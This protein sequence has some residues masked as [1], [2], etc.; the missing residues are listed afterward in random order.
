MKAQPVQQGSR[1]VFQRLQD[2]TVQATTRSSASNF[3]AFY[4]RWFQ[5][6][7]RRTLRRWVARRPQSTRPLL[8]VLEDRTTPTVVD[9]T[10]LGSSGSILGAQFIQGVIGSA[11]T[12][13]IQSFVRI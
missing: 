6:P 2:R 12:G 8:E 4:R 13:V 3:L 10:S 11:G 5:S 7:T 9:L 1:P